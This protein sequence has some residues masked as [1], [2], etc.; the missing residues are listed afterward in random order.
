MEKDKKKNN[1]P[2]NIENSLKTRKET[3]AQKKKRFIKAYSTRLCNVSTACEIVGVS[4]TTYY[5]WVD[6]DNTFKK[7]IEDAN[8]D[9]Y[10]KLETTMFGKAITDKDTTMLIW[11]SKTKMKHRGYVEKQEQEVTVNPFEEIMKR[12]ATR[13]KDDE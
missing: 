13:K 1:L 10:D 8:E 2:V 6:K 9:F 4:R 7:A 11:L 12:V 3:T 5:K